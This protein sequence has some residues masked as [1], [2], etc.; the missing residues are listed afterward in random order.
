MADKLSC[1]SCQFWEKSE[2]GMIQDITK[3]TGICQGVPPTVLGVP[4]Q[5]PAGPILQIQCIQPITDQ[6]RVACSL[7]KAVD[8]FSQG[9]AQ[10]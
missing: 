3:I 2:N 6:N 7:F 5:G 1:K 8:L 4:M 10:A 9:F